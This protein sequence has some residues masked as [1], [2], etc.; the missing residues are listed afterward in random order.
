MRNII[1][2][3]LKRT[4]LNARRWL[5]RLTG[6]RDD[7]AL[8]TKERGH[9]RRILLIRLDR[10]GDMVLSTPF[11]ASLK[12]AYPRAEISL[13]ARP[14]A[15]QLIKPENGVDR[16]VVCAGGWAEAAQLARLQT[17]DLAVDMHYDHI[18][19]PA[20]A[21]A[22]SGA[23]WRAG[24]AIA[25][26]EAFFNLHAP[27]GKPRHFLDEMADLLRTL[28]AEP[29]VTKPFLAAPHP[30][31]A[32]DELNRS[33]PKDSSARLCVIHPGGYYPEQRWP[34]ERFVALARRLQRKFGTAIVVL[35]GLTESRLIESIARAC[36]AKTFASADAGQTAAL[37]ARADLFIG[38]NSGPLHMACALGV[39]SVS[40]MGPTD[41]R[42]FWPVG[43]KAVVVQ[44]EDFDVRRITLES[45]S[46][47]AERALA[48]P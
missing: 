16:I 38:N 43:E 28:R 14:F 48:A 46:A 40:T 9:I 23:K 19:G 12:A 30:C 45:M 29:T 35:G 13:L 4:C 34:A 17:P 15:A 44:T 32:V 5:L 7:S 41:P 27:V 33:S 31:E 20:L 24:F 25:G 18:L 1:R 37:L 11:F 21:C 42:R 10:L 47:A 39:A 36:D 8:F 3:A 6:P 2:P 22:W 26:R